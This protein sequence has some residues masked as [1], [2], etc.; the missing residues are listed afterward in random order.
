M[1]APACPTI[2]HPPNDAS[3]CWWLAVNY[4][5]FHQ[6]RPEIETFL[7]RG[8]DVAKQYDTISKFYRGDGG[9][10][11]DVEAARRSEVLKKEFNTDDFTLEG[12]EYQDASQYVNKLLNLIDIPFHTVTSALLN[13]TMYDI[14]LHRL[15]VGV[16]VP[17][18]TIIESTGEKYRIE[19]FQ[20]APTGS[21]VIFFPRMREVAEGRNQ[22]TPLETPVKV[23]KEIVVPV[24]GEAVTYE[25]DAMVAVKPG[26]YYSVVKCDGKWFEHG[27]RGGIDGTHTYENFEELD[28]STNATLLFYTRA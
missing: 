26:H 14:D 13:F 21:L 1:S 5:L 10:K 19:K 22:T 9:T 18:N 12:S 20:I 24:E 3:T 23:L 15:A 16:K 27:G 2:N 4:A 25:L 17:T 8:G 28:Y 11:A 6:S 7:A